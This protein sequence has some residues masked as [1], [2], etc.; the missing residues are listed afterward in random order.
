MSLISA[1]LRREIIGPAPACGVVMMMFHEF[2]KA[3][4]VGNEG[5]PIASYRDDFA[6]KCR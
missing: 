3:Y 1:N 4:D 6:L 5:H 2:S